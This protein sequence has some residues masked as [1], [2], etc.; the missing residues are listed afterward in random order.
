MEICVSTNVYAKQ[1]YVPHIL[2]VDGHGHDRETWAN[3]LYHFVQ[4]IFR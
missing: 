4:R 1:H 3:N 2:S